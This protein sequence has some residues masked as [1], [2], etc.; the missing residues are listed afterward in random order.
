MS[1]ADYEKQYGMVSEDGG[2][3]KPTKSLIQH[4]TT[5]Q[6]RKSNPMPNPP[7]D[8]ILNPRNKNCHPCNREFNRRQAF[9]EHC[10]NVHDIKIKFAKASS[11]TTF[12]DFKPFTKQPEDPIKRVIPITLD[13]GYACQYCGKVFNNPSNR[14]RH[15][16]LHCNLALSNAVETRKVEKLIKKSSKN[17]R[18]YF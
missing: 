12:I 4:K 1:P 18:R 13:K 2:K 14:R 5:K 11:G 9:V 3:S 16:R 8:D 17:N 7:E 10:R 15:A 6:P